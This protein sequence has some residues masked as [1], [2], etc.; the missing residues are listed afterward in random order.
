MSF[1]AC[2]PSGVL[3]R[4]LA[5]G[6]FLGIAANFITWL[7]SFN[8]FYL[9]LFFC[10]SSAVYFG[11]SP[12][13]EHS[14]ANMTILQIKQ[15]FEKFLPSARNRHTSCWTKQIFL[16][17]FG[18]FQSKLAIRSTDTLQAL[19]SYPTQLEDKKS[20]RILVWIGK[21]RESV[22]LL[23]TS[24]I[25][26]FSRPLNSG[27]RFVTG[28]RRIPIFQIVHRLQYILKSSKVVFSK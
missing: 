19:Y 16:P 27:F 26:S 20:R 13:A 21:K 17:I 23:P 28:K 11:L 22:L 6:V 14:C 7:L 24:W 9:F 1:G 25:G 15:P 12:T 3:Q 4:T 18:F 10:L 5:R 2:D 8:L